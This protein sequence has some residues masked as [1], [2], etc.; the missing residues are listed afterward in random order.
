MPKKS[1]HI[2]ALTDNPFNEYIETLSDADANEL[3]QFFTEFD[4]HCLISPIE[5]NKLKSDFEKAIIYYINSGIPQ[6]D[7]LRLLD[8]KNMGGF[9][10]RPSVLW[11]PLDDAAKIYPLSIEHGRMS[12]FRLSVYLKKEIV[13]ELLQMALNF[14]IKRFPSFATTLKKGFFWHYLDTTKRRFCVQQEDDI[15]CQPL[16]VSLSGSQSFR[17]I[18]WQNRISIEFFHVL[19]DGTGGLTFLKV[20][21]AEYLR[22]TGVEVIPDDTLWDINATPSINELENAFEKVPQGNTSSG[23]LDKIAV[24]M[25]SKLAKNKPCHILHFKMDTSQ[26]KK[27]ASDY[28]VTI[29]VYILALMFIA[30]KNATDDLTGSTSIQ[31]PVN[32]RKFY[33]SDTVRNFSLYCGIRMPIEEITDVKSII[34]GINEQLRSKASKDIMSEM[35][36]S[37]RKMVGMLKYVPLSIKQP[38]AKIVYGF[39]GDKVFTNTL[40]NVGVVKLPKAVAEQVES[41]DMVL[42]TAITNRVGCALITVNNT[43]TLSIT[44]MTVD[45]SF[46]EKLYELLSEGGITVSVEGSEIY[47]T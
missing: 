43:T 4:A 42:G 36:T 15:P 21:T 24:Q 40:S 26:L 47:E 19:T 31:V 25:S 9:Y 32:M 35:L 7:A 11:F 22:L 44:K 17:V 38:I 34:N 33:P 5:K 2:K 8:T 20:L 30:G 18:Y 10:A 45:P 27:A 12:V 23:F 37:T 14:T 28:G 1:K 16:K 3:K 46:E 39:L 41:M 6:R 13:P 29:T